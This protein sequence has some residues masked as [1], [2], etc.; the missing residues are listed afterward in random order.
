MRTPVSSGDQLDHYRIEDPIIRSSTTSIFR[1]TDINT[2][3]EVAIEIPNP[4]MEGDP[5]FFERFQREQEIGRSLDHPGL[6]KTLNPD[7]HRSQPYIVTEW[8]D[9]ETLRE[10]LKEEKL[11]PE[12]AVR[13]AIS[14]CDVLAYIHSHGVVHRGLKPENVLVDSQDHIKLINFGTASKIGSRRITFTNLSRVVGV[15]DYISPEELN[16]KRG[17]N[18]SDIYALG[19][20]LYEML[21]GRTPFQGGEPYDRVLKNPTPPREIDPSISPQLQEVV[22]RAL[23]RQ[24]KDRYASAHEFAMDLTHLDRVGV[25]DRAELRD[26]KKRRWP[27][28]KRV[29]FYVS[30][31]LIPIALFGLLLLFARG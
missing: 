21:T 13:I 25:E 22:Y 10:M 14:I 23:E 7:E 24:Y 28:M 30:L 11:S 29:L 15:S 2:K 6:L 18:R 3:R 12:R 19:V 31:A 8:F 17:D 16:G 20:I 5:V 9:G 26:W 4:E 27:R 1:A